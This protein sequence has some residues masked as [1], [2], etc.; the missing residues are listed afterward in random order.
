MSRHS[1]DPRLT[2]HSKRTVRFTLPIQKGIITLGDI[3]VRDGAIATIVIKAKDL[4]D[5][6]DYTLL[7]E[8]SW[9]DFLPKGTRLFA[10]MCHPSYFDTRFREVHGIE[11]KPLPPPEMERF[12]VA[13]S[14]FMPSPYFPANSFFIELELLQQLHI[15]LPGGTKRATLGDCNCGIPALSREAISLNHAYSLIS[16]VFEPH[17]KGHGGNVFKKVFYEYGAAIAP[18]DVLRIQKEKE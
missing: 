2:D 10:M 9:K 14:N 16:E 5:P 18:L 17:R 8:E 7:T 15:C 12:I 4:T 11:A 3:D 6:K 1:N 13:P